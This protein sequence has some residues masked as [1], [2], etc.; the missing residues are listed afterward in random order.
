MM[1]YKTLAATLMISLVVATPAVAADD[2]YDVVI[3]NGRVMDPESGLDA[4]RN[5][6]LRA[7]KIAA[8]TSE[9]IQGRRTIDAKGLVVAPGFIDLHEHG[10]KPENYAFQA[11]DGV[12]TSLE[13]EAGTA[14]V[15]GWYA[16]REG[17][18]LINFGVSVGHIPAR[19]KVMKDP[20]T[21]LPTGDAAHRAATEAELAQI[22]QRIDAGLKQGA[23]AVGM[24]I[25]YTAAATRGEVLNV[26]R[27]AARHGAP[28]HV[29]LR[30]GGDKP[31]ETARAAL[32]EVLA[33]SSET[34]AP[35]HVVHVSSMG[36]RDTPQLLAMIRAARARGADVTTECYPYVAGSTGLESA[37]FDPG[38]Q[39]RMRISY[40]DLQ[41]VKTGERLTAETFARYRKEGGQVVIFMIPESVVR[42]AVADPMVMIAS[43]G[44]PA[45]GASVHPRGQGT[46]SR[47]LGKYVREEKALDLMTALRKMTLMPA[48]RLEQRAPA[49]KTKGRIRSGA[50]ADI[51]IFDA[52][53]VIDA[54]TFE[55]PLQYSE[56]IR[57]VLING[58]PVVSE[59]KLVEGV[60]PG[61]A[62]RA[63]LVQ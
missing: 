24:G 53:R 10:Q 57:F 18:S 5:V 40:G 34:K 16:E 58:E 35:L 20:G 1:L 12:T 7:G 29:H 21:W 51:T 50:D 6:G 59:G 37:L 19:M 23:L 22:D 42:L 55:K 39:E 9:A 14:D 62:A 4:V 60:F 49:F 38:W 63:P 48:Q 45:A 30:Y 15:A 56:G 27:V 43:D 26:F 47:V 36:L 54:A 32:E 46:F 61:R 28:V 2:P 17:K 25:N 41:W 44:M 11:H 33:A 8:V 3:A 52:D 31:P 13:L